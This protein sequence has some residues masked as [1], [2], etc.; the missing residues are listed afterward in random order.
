MP[1]VPPMTMMD[2]FRKS[3]GIW[4]TQRTVHH[5]DAVADESGESKLHV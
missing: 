3:E 4:L 2:F 1:L 5:F